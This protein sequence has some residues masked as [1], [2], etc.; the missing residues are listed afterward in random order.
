MIQRHKPLRILA[1]A[2]VTSKDSVG[3]RSDAAAPRSQQHSE[4]QGLAPEHAARRVH[5]NFVG[6]QDRLAGSAGQAALVWLRDALQ[7]W[8]SGRLACWQRSVAMASAMQEELAE[9]LPDGDLG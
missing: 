7:I 4:F 5:G 2:H 1:G 8:S 3:S 6:D 9:S